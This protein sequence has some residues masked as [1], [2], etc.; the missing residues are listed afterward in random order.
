MNVKKGFL[1]KLASAL[2]AIMLITAC[3][4]N[5]EEEPGNEEPASEEP[6][7][8]ETNTEDGESSEEGS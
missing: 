6:A 8:E 4:G 2:F 3:N 1:A 5:A 7:E